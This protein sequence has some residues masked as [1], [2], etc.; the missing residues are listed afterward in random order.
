M[1]RADAYRLEVRDI[2]EQ[3]VGSI[4][5]CLP[6]AELDRWIETAI[7]ELFARLAQQRV[8]PAGP[9]F[10]IRP[11]PD[12]DRAIELE[13]ALPAIRRVAPRGRM[14][15]RRVSA[16]RAL[17]TLHCGAHDDVGSAYE[18]LAAAIEQHGIEPAGSPREVYRTNPVET[19][20][21][22]CETEVLWPVDV[23]ASWRLPAPASRRL[24]VRRATS[25][26]A[27]RS[28]PSP[29]RGR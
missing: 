10:V 1:A 19:S 18:A 9:P 22:E 20:P 23:P 5:G 12:G 21:D 8:Q 3:I 26:A 27:A 17:W 7:H 2:P 14:T 29:R 11:A 15:G 16:C 24:R 6:A 4:H 25:R 28:A 13:V